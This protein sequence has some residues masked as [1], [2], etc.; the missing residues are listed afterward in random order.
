MLVDH[1]DDDVDDCY[2]LCH[3]LHYLQVTVHFTASST[4]IIIRLVIVVFF[5]VVLF[6]VIFLV[7]RCYFLG[8]FVASFLFVVVIVEV[9]V[10]LTVCTSP[11]CGCVD[12]LL[13]F[14]IGTL[15]LFSTL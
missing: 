11:P 12:I 10:N 6:C 13:F 7:C 4:L 9:I 5:I 3:P 8:F 14:Y 1:D 2:L 15:V